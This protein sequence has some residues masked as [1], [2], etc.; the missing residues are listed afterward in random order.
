VGPRGR[1]G[2]T[3]RAEPDV[4]ERVRRWARERSDRRGETRGD[5]DVWASS[6]TRL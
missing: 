4:Q 1:A 5:A 6:S 2:P 3:D